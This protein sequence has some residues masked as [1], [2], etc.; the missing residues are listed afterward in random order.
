MISISSNSIL[1]EN[2]ST[3][4]L[5]ANEIFISAHVRKGL[6]SWCSLSVTATNGAGQAQ[7]GNTFFDIDN[8]VVGS[9]VPTNSGTQTLAGI[10]AVSG[11]FYIWVVVDC[12]G[13]DTFGSTW[14]LRNC[15]DD[16]DTTSVFDSVN[17]GIYMGGVMLVDGASGELPYIPT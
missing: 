17:P 7:G 13:D 1:R 4:I 12:Q 10:R 8:G 9:F 6:T 14:A 16:L 2:L 11:G 5:D 3:N 15:T